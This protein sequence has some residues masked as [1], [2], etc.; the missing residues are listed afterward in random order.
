M[1]KKGRKIFFILLLVFLLLLIKE[2]GFTAP[3]VANKAKILTIDN[4]IINPVTVEYI[5]RGLKKA[6]DSSAVLV[7]KMDT[8]GGLLKSTQEIVKLI[9]NAKVP[10]VTYVYPKGA[11][12]A[13]A[14]VFV[15]YAS[16]ILAMA[17]STHI[18]AAHPIIGGGR[19]GSLDKETKEKIINDTLSWAENIAHLR[20]RPV[21]FIKEAVNKST[22][23]TE[24]EALKKRVCDLI[25]KDLDHL[26]EKIDGRVIT[27]EGKDFKFATKKNVQVEEIPLTT[28]EKI[29][30]AL[31][32]PNIAYLL[33]TLGFLGLI[34]EVTHP[35]FGFP[36]IAG[37]ICLLLSFYALSVL[38]GN[39]VGLCFIVLGIILFVV[40]AF[41][42]TWGMFT[43]G[44]V[45]SFLLGTLMIFNQPEV[46]RVSVKVFL[47]IVLFFAGI[48]FFLLGKIV[49]AQRQTSSV[50]KNGLLK[51]V[52]EAITDISEGEGKVSIHGEIWRAYSHQAIKKGDKVRV[53]K[54]EGLN[55]YVRKEEG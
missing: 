17:P 4:Y 34:F 44:G 12:A 41:T 48:S 14:G 2:E 50:G 33:L 49:L 29:L 13:S 28:R 38:P 39:Y 51:A 18:G 46:I 32:D 19:W 5:K 30:N 37:L 26:W 43:L 25:A 7:L 11:R 35:G 55:L 47:P 54:V 6:E 3:L 22:S 16:H 1:E 52:G 24:K 42:P 27:A 20:N 40:E 8:P 36:G 31:I 45:A 15:G 9:L 53:E 23:I 21:S 10:V